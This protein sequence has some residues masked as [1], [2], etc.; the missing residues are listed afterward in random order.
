MS[1]ALGTDPLRQSLF[2]KTA[3]TGAPLAGVPP[4]SAGEVPRTSVPS[5]PAEAAPAPAPPAEHLP[6][7]LAILGF[8]LG[9]R[10][11]GLDIHCVQRIVRMVEVTELPHAVPFLQGVVDVMGLVVPVISLRRLFGMP[12]LPISLEGHIIISEVRGRALGLIVDSVTDLGTVSRTMIDPP[13]QI[14]PLRDFLLGV[15]RLQ[16]KISFLLKPQRLVEILETSQSPLARDPTAP[17]PGPPEALE[18]A[19]P[20]PPVLPEETRIRTIL[21][22]RAEELSR[23]PER[24]DT[25]RRQLLTF[26]LGEESYGVDTASVRTI[27]GNPQ[28]VAVP[29][30][31]GYVAGVINLRGEILTVVNLRRFFGLPESSTPRKG[32]VV[33]TERQRNCVGFIVDAVHDVIELPTDIIERPLSTIE[34]IRADYIEGEA[35]LEDRLLGIL[36][37]EAAMSP[38]PVM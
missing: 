18:P 33:V 12:S 34:K 10:E 27:V 28:I 5:A 23:K 4:A 26:S 21:H 32:Q 8:R 30:S 9:R 13:D 36:R 29:S 38:V 14:T 19:E 35:R 31:P 7:E 11:F 15:A 24:D 22:Q 37:L 1:R 6:K 17:W 25:P 20:H 3:P 2:K 16:N